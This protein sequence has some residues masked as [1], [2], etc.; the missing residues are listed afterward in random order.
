MA[1]STKMRM[2][3]GLDSKGRFRIQTRGSIYIVK[4][5]WM[6][7]GILICIFM[8]AF[9]IDN[10]TNRI[11]SQSIINSNISF[12]GNTNDNS[13]IIILLD[14]TN[15]ITCNNCQLHFENITIE[16][17]T[18]DNNTFTLN[19]HSIL[20]LQNVKITSQQ[21]NNTFDNVF[22]NWLFYNNAQF[23]CNKCLFHSLDS[24]TVQFYDN[25]IFN[26]YNTI[27]ANIISISE[28]ITGFITDSNNINISLNNCIVYDNEESPINFIHIIYSI[29][30]DYTINIIHSE[31]KFWHN[32][33]TT[34][35]GGILY[36]T[37]N[38]KINI[39]ST[40]ITDSNSFNGGVIYAE[41]CTINIINCY[42]SNNEADNDG[43]VIY[44]RTGYILLQSVQFYANTADSLA[45]SCFFLRYTMYIYI[46]YTIL[47]NGR[48]LDLRD[49]NVTAKDVHYIENTATDYGATNYGKRSMFNIENSEWIGNH[50]SASTALQ[51]VDCE[52][53]CT[54]C[55][56]Q[57]NI[58]IDGFGGLMY[59][60]SA[61]VILNHVEIINS[62][63]ATR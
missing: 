42:I 58:G 9:N 16:I 47:D 7:V 46:N 2:T 60:L 38:G 30:N 51:C 37:S 33:G 12:I 31:F 14:L 48:V 44:M 29:T 35:E 18:P 36:L 6:F 57:N 1:R 34:A 62:S 41:N 55:L 28:S 63:A 17:P 24:L 15:D 49:V 43:G 19:E 23:I 54:H 59:L 53:I 10:G 25:T 40:N 22:T 26:A 50:A 52:F 4:T 21:Y 11:L 45:L 27:F 32:T 39:D 61:N 3:K 20:S 5:V 8:L 56:F 13:N